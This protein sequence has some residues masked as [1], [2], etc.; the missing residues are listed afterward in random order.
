MGRV[1][2][3]ALAQSGSAPAQRNDKGPLTNTVAVHAIPP[4]YK[5]NTL[6]YGVKHPKIYINE[7]SNY[8]LREKPSTIGSNEMQPP[9]HVNAAW[10]SVVETVRS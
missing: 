7:R 8:S 4:S 3:A 10:S 5:W 1:R 2:R 6:K 9:A